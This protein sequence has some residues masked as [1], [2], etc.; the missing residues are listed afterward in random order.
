LNPDTVV[1]TTHKTLEVEKALA[2]KAKTPMEPLIITNTV[3][4]SDV[5]QTIDGPEQSLVFLVS[6]GRPQLLEWTHAVSTM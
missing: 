2:A 6:A 1:Q 5:V 4:N 3:I